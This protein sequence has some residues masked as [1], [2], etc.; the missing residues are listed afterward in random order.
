MECITILQCYPVVK[1]TLKFYDV[2]EIVRLL[3]E[4]YLLAFLRFHHLF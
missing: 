1:L 3:T 2:A 4:L